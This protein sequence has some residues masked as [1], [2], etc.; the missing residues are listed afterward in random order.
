MRIS[1][2]APL[3]SPQNDAAYLKALARGA[4]ERGFHSIWLGEHVVLFDD[5]DAQYPY[6]QDGRIPIGG[7]RGLLE[8]MT[9]LSF[10]AAHTQ[11][12][13]LGTGICLVPQRNPVYTAKEVAAVDYLSGGRVDFGVGIGWLKEEFDALDTPFARRG[14]RCREYLEVIASL[15]T[16]DVSSYSGEFYQLPPCRQYPKPVQQPGPPIFFGGESNAAL[17]RVADIGDGWYGY[18][19]AVEE[20]K[21]CLARLD[22]MLAANSRRR[23]DLEIAICPYSHKLNQD[24]AAQYQDCGVDQ[25]VLLIVGRDIDELNRWLDRYAA[26]YL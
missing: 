11:R 23:E 12:I 26:D 7:D 15:W 21:A 17:R 14:A 22:D 3:I 9:A 25:L 1:L 6:A 2:F 10:I 24:S 19:V 4:E 5:Y 8:P 13:R 16:Q 20:T 18:N